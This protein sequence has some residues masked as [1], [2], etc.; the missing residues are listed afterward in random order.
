M[1]W[2]ELVG[3]LH[4]HLGKVYKESPGKTMT[5]RSKDICSFNKPKVPS[6]AMETKMY[7]ITSPCC[8]SW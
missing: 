2:E 3:K 6:T 7:E 5:E 4:S 8:R 1:T